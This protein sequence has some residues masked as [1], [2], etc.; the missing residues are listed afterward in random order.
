MANYLK[1]VMR[2]LQRRLQGGFRKEERVPDDVKTGHVAVHA[3]A[4]EGRELQRFIVEVTELGRPE[5]MRLLERAE[6]EFGYEQEGVLVVPCCAD[7]L[8]KILNHN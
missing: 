3:M 6:E 8:Q 4:V 5:F 1:S 7:E 2:K